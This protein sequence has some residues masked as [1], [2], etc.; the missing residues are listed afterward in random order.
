MLAIGRAMMA[1]QKFLI[2]DE[3]SLGLAPLIVEKVIANIIKISET[4]IPILLVEQSASLALDKY[5]RAYVFDT[6][7]IQMS[8]MSSKLASD[9]DA[10]KAY[11]GIA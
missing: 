7:E 11:L 10:K 1:Q 9:N 8:G 4:G 2:F 3:S 6:G 5:D